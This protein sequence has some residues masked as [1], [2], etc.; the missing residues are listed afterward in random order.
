MLFYNLRFHLIRSYSKLHSLTTTL[1]RSD[2]RNKRILLFK[3]V[4]IKKK[5]NI[6]RKAMN[7]IL[8]T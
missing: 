3:S 6:K 1:F 2:D 4:N 8:V 7:T 5:V